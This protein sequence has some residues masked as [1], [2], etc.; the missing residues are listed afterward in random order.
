METN[1][2]Q[3]Q[4]LQQRRRFFAAALPEIECCLDKPKDEAAKLNT[5]PAC[6]YPTLSERAGYEICAICGWED[7]GQD[8]AAADVV[9]GGANGGYS[10]SEYRLRVAEELARLT[11][12]SATLEAEYR[13]IGRELRALQLLINQ[14]QA[15][16]QDSVIQQVFVVIGLFSERVR[17][18]K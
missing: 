4:E 10:L 3:P 16:M 7:D 5:C 6:G 9:W 2:A 13:K 12:A 1:V 14:Y 11:V 15:E 17:P 18:K 8:D